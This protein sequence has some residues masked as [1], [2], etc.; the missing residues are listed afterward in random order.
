MTALGL[1]LVGELVPL[2]AYTLRMCPHSSYP[3]E[4]V[5]VTHFSD[6]LC[7]WAYVSQVRI[8]E[9]KSQFR[10]KIAVDY[11]LFPVFGDAV[12]K[13]NAQWAGKSGRKGYN[14]HVLEI[15]SKFGHVLVHP[16]IWMRDMPKSSLPA[17]LFLCAIRLAESAGALEPGS[18]ER[19]TWIVRQAFF[20][21][22]LNIS[23]QSVLWQLASEAGLPIDVIDFR[24]KSGESH[25]AL[26]NDMQS[27]RDLMVRS[28]PT[29]I[30]NEDRQRLSGNVGYRIIEAN[31]R[32][33]LERPQG[34]QSWC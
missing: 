18:L 23:E 20:A 4:I 1:G 19:M 34:Q 22:L 28:S 25:A 31:I 14:A 5:R 21:R 26:S 16:D 7:V 33:L 8:D 3:T 10:E 2:F 30:F 17:H 13:I 9:L 15:A 27:A 24:L 32:E 11:R 12:H 6:V 29:M